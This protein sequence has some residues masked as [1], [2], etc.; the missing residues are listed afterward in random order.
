MTKIAAT[1]IYGKTLQNSSSPEPVDQFP[2]KLACSI[3]D[4]S[5]SWFIQM[6]TLGDLDL[7]HAKAKFDKIGFSIGKVKTSWIFQKV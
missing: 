7:I 5:P 6:M 4:S 2:R 1:L 3:G